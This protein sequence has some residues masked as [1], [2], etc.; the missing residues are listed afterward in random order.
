[1]TIIGYINTVLLTLLVL[2]TSYAIPYFIHKGWLDAENDTTPRKKVCDLCFRDIGKV[3]DA[4]HKLPNDP[5]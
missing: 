4:L 3:R 5:V 1:M 2:L